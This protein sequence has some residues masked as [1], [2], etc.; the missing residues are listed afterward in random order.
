MCE[1][2]NVIIIVDRDY[3]YRIL[4]T[5]VWGN[6]VCEVIEE[7]REGGRRRKEEGRQGGEGGRERQGGRER[8]WEVLREKEE[9]REWR[10]GGRGAETILGKRALAY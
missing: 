9:R 5:N 10:E 4:S 8:A 6:N 7:R 3:Y 1:V 2:I